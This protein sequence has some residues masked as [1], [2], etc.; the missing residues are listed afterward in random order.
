MSYAPPA[1][2]AV[3]LSAVFSSW[4]MLCALGAAPPPAYAAPAPAPA[5]PASAAAAVGPAASGPAKQGPAA[6]GVPAAEVRL[7][8]P[9]GS[10][11][12]RW[13]SPRP[14]TWQRRPTVRPAAAAVDGG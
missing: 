12:I 10:E 6:Q 3:R 11:L 13:P 5:S 8:A 9:D 7:T 4:A 2:R 14:P 1:V